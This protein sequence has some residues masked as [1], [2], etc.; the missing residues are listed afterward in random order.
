MVTRKVKIMI[1]TTW[2]PPQR[3][4]M[5]L[6][7]FRFASTR[8]PCRLTPSCSGSK[9]VIWVSTEFNPIEWDWSFF[10]T[11]S[12][13]DLAQE[14]EGGDTQQTLQN[15]LKNWPGGSWE[16][17]RGQAHRQ[18]RLWSC[19]GASRDSSTHPSLS[20]K[21]EM[22]CNLVVDFPLAERVKKAPPGITSLL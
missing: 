21:L 18:R 14:K 10:S 22:D 17:S 13:K 5:K 3:I 16:W 20:L 4:R 12:G 15:K 2:P 7:S 6:S 1:L 8:G 11:W 9:W 19:A